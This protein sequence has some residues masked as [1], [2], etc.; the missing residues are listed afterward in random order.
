MIFLHMLMQVLDSLVPSPTEDT[1]LLHVIAELPVGNNQVPLLLRDVL[2]ELTAPR[3]VQNGLPLRLAELMFLIHGDHRQWSLMFRILAGVQLNVHMEVVPCG[4][5]VM[6]SGA[7]WNAIHGVLIGM[8]VMLAQSGV[9]MDVSA[10]PS[11]VG[12]IGGAE[13]TMRTNK[14]PSGLNG[15]LRVCNRNWLA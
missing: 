13:I 10:M 2:N 14:V 3:S 12:Q 8:K 5:G 6:T 1:M 9:M 4:K 11:K 7:S 15:L